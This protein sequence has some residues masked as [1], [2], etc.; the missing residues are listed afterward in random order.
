MMPVASC[1]PLPFFASGD[2]VL[3][4]LVC[5]TRWLS[6]HLYTLVYMSM[7][8]SCLLVCRPCFNTM[9][10]WTFNLNLHLSLTD[11]DFCLLSCLFAFSLACLLAFLFFAYHIYR[12]YLLYI[13]FV[14]I[15]NLFFPLLVCWFLVFTFACTHMEW[16]CMELGH[17]LP[18]VSKKGRGC[19]HIDISQVAMFSR[20]RCLVSLIWLC[21]LL[22]PLLSSLIS[23]LNGLY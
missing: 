1:I 10:L 2:D 8:E 5:A 9:K 17:G 3:T 20:F 14:C 21:T 23:L 13:S 7:L 22:N 11:T 12:A 4:M 18:G 6:M 19:K 16:G 15:L